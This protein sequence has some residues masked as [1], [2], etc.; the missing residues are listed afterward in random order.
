MAKPPPFSLQ[1]SKT[2]PPARAPWLLAMDVD[3]DVVAD[4]AS[5]GITTAP[6]CKGKPRAPRKTATAPKKNKELT[7]EERARE[8]TKRKGWRYVADARDE[9]A[10]VA[11]ITVAAQ[12]EDTV[13]RVT[14]ATREVLLYL[15]LNNHQHGLVNAV[16]TTANIGSFAFPR[17]ALLE[18]PRTSTT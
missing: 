12:R 5:S 9:A 4:L 16:V 7:P 13:A 17:M 11:A 1:F 8:S 18:S 15:V 3:L 10:A 6:S 2:L 14:T